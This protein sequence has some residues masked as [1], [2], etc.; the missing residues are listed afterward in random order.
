LCL[1]VVSVSAHQ[2][3]SLSRSFLAPNLVCCFEGSAA[4]QAACR[5]PPPDPNYWASCI[6]ATGRACGGVDQDIKFA[7]LTLGSVHIVKTYPYNKALFSPQG[8]VDNPEKNMVALH[9]SIGAISHDLCCRQNLHGTFCNAHNM[10]I[11]NTFAS[12]LPL[13]S[14]YNN[15]CACLEEWRRAA[16]E[17]YAGFGEVMN[18]PTK[19][20]PELNKPNPTTR[21]TTLPGD[22]VPNILNP[23]SSS[24]KSWTPLLQPVVE[25]VGTSNIKF[26]NGTKLTCIATAD[27]NCR[28]QSGSS[29]CNIQ[30]DSTCKAGSAEAKAWIPSYAK[31]GDA[32][33]CASGEFS[34]LGYVNDDEGWG[35]CA[36]LQK[37]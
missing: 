24:G 4:D 29:A 36:P 15:S 11:L 2:A 23:A 3:S 16:F 30:A 27:P 37:K 8:V 25:T 33:W 35:I 10:P 20:M 28:I 9:T 12:K 6:G 22:F 7:G 21:K 14:K 1:A 19:P 18:W 34:R 13:G 26:S 5:N 17:F 31:A 32:P